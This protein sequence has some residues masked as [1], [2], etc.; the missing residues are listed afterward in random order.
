M[1]AAA[2]A[3]ELAPSA[4]TIN[5]VSMVSPF[6]NVTVG[7]LDVVTDR[8]EAMER[9]ERPFNFSGPSIFLPLILL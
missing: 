4:P 5:R 2:L 8:K 9:K 1:P 7:Q 6:D 3:A